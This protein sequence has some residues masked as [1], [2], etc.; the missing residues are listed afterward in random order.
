MLFR[1]QKDE[2]PQI[3]KYMFSLILAQF[4]HFL[5]ALSAN[6]LYGL[7]AAFQARQSKPTLRLARADHFLSSDIV[8]GLFELKAGAFVLLG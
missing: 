1:L 8:S 6:K 4:Q 3:N 5:K 2:S 7:S